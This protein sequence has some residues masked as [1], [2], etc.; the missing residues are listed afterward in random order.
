[1]TQGPMFP[2][3]GTAQVFSRAWGNSLVSLLPT[4]PRPAVMAPWLWG[5]PLPGPTDRVLVTQ[6]RAD[7]EQ[8]ACLLVDTGHGNTAPETGRK[9]SVIAQMRQRRSPHFRA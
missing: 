6:E 7:R 5:T 8:M 4:V 9:P 1:M 2:Q 3:V